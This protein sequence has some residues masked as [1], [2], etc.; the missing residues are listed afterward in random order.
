M[1]TPHRFKEVIADRYEIISVLGQGGTG[2]TYAA[3]DRQRNWKVALKA[4][5]FRRVKDWKV[6]ELF[7]REAQI[8]GNLK[9]P[10]IPAY[11]HHFQEQTDRDLNF[12]L[13]QQLAP[14]KSLSESVSQ[15]WRPTNEEIK[16]IAVQV[17]EILVYLQ[18]LTPAVIHRD[19]KPQNIIRQSD[20]KVFLVDFGAVQDTYHNTVTGGSTIVG[21]FGYMAPEQFRGQAV[22]STDLYGLGTTLLFLLTGRS[23]ADLPQNHL[24]IQFRDAIDTSDHFTDFLE[25]MIEPI[26]TARFSSAN[27]ALA[28]LRERQPIIP[29]AV[30]YQRPKKTKIRLTRTPDR[31][32]IDIPYSFLDS[33]KSLMFSIIPFTIILFIWISLYDWSSELF[34][35]TF[36]EGSLTA[37]ILIKIGISLIIGFPITGLLILLLSK[38][39]I[40]STF[41]NTRVEITPGWVLKIRK[42][43]WK[44]SFLT[45]YWSE[46]SQFQ[47]RSVLYRFA[48]CAR[49]ASFCALKYKSNKITFGA[50]LRPDEQAWLIDEICSFAKEVESH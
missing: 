3:T 31:L 44:I 21:T 22:L 42:S 28:V 43:L 12:Y 27:E 50:F 11:Y 32:V 5:S 4:L 17:L 1:Y 41:F 34:R 19:I 15:G 23:P 46:P 36:E 30:I 8:L 39:L 33:S 38:T 25:Q 26:S 49:P 24:R 37:L 35:A 47:P 48:L 20:G 13:V 2:V 9:H 18:Q 29:R 14:G 6:L 10:G 45:T 7:E 16:D 40:F